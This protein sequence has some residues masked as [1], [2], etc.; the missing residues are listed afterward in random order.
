MKSINS[1]NVRNLSSLTVLTASLALLGGCIAEPMTAEEMAIAEAEEML[2]A[3]EVCDGIDNDENFRIDEGNL[4]GFGSRSVYGNHEYIR[5]AADLNRDDAIAACRGRGYELVKIDDAGEDAWIANALNEA[6][7]VAWLGMSRTA[8]KDPWVW[9][10]G[11]LVTYENWAEPP[12]D[13]ALFGYHKA[14]W[15]SSPSNSWKLKAMCELLDPVTF[16]TISGVTT[17]GG[18]WITKTGTTAAG[19]F[20]AQSITGTDG[21]IQFVAGE[22]TKEKVVGLSQTDENLAYSSI[23][24]GIRLMADGSIRVHEQA[25]GGAAD[26]G[27]M[28]TYTAEDVFR[29]ELVGGKVRYLKNGFVFHGAKTAPSGPL[30]LDATLV[31]QGASVGDMRVK[32]CATADCNRRGMWKNVRSA[33]TRDGYLERLANTNSSWYNAGASTYDEIAPGANGYAEFSTR[34][35]TKEKRV[36]LALAGKAV[37]DFTI[38]YSFTLLAD[39]R[40]SICFGTSSCFITGTYDNDDVLRVERLD[41]VIRYVKNGDVLYTRNVDPSQRLTMAAALK[42]QGATVTEASIRTCAAGDNSCINRGMWKNVEYAVASGSNLK[43]YA[44]GMVSGASSFDSIPLGSTGYVEFKSDETTTTKW[45]GL[46]VG[47]ATFS[48]GDIEYRIALRQDGMVSTGVGSS[49]DVAR[50]VTYTTTDVFRVELG[51]TTNGA[52]AVFFKKNGVT[53]HTETNVSLITGPLVLDTTMS[54]TDAT[55][56]N[57]AIVVTSP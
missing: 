21:F 39:G 33:M 16:A 11:T 31:T 46:G 8:T 47:D 7:V 52:R 25:L 37:G 50:N 30:F 54:S 34:E 36:G 6:A 18:T 9:S 19:A 26:E 17:N 3:P 10:D 42:D 24:Y 20:S 1:I 53:F 13:D 2:V 14:G 48:S 45:A 23:D 32:S 15:R 51:T 29:V 27:N 22:T 28:G 44:Q 12:Q 41:G 55:I 5:S 57:A 49:P 43:R 4:C 38:E 56:K 40:F 35:S